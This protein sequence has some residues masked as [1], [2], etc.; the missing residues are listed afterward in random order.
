MDAL[1]V[2]PEK[3]EK[4][5]DYRNLAGLLRLCSFIHI[6]EQVGYFWSTPLLSRIMTPERVI[7][8]LAKECRGI[9]SSP[10]EL[11]HLVEV[12]LAVIANHLIA[13]CRTDC[14]KGLPQGIC[15]V[16]PRFAWW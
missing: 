11:E 5:A 8:A 4:G 9:P 3:L 13:L 7:E 1:V 16:T 15:A 14:S 6:D 10:T 12:I 2:D